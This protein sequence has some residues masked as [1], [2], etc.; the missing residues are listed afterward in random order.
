MKL[1]HTYWWIKHL[2][3]DIII[4]PVPRP[5]CVICDTCRWSAEAPDFAI[6]TIKYCKG[7]KV[8]LTSKIG[9]LSNWDM[10]TEIYNNT[11][12]LNSYRSS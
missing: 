8:Y 12:Y 6:T 5:F 9:N 4:F 1:P 10:I 11:N 3:C 7:I 2:P